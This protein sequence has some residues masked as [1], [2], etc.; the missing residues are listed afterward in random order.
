MWTLIERLQ[1]RLEGEGLARDVIDAAIV[2]AVRHAVGGPL[3]GQA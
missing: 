3:P 1:R 2:Q